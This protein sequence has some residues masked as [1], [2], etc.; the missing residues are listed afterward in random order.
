M[1][2]AAHLPGESFTQARV[3]ELRAWMAARSGD[4]PAERAALEALIALEPADAT[5]V[6]RLADLAAQDGERERLAELR[7]RKADIENA[8]N[9][10]R[11]LINKPEL[12]PLAAELAR[13]ADG[14]GRRFDAAAWW[15]IAAQRDPALEREAAAARA[16]LAKAEAPAA[17]G[18]TL[19]DLLGPL[20]SP[21][22]GKGAAPA[23]LSV[24]TFVDDARAPGPCLH[25]RQRAQRRITSS[26]RP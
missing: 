7:R 1:R 8:R 20:R 2:A 5:A 13:A 6:A 3:L 17:G 15:R 22:G 26:P 18:G 21:A 19:A 25:F 23:K 14:I 4:R 10:Y 11:R 16:R 24:P 12:A 9:D